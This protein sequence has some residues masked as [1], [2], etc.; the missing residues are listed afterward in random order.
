MIHLILLLC[1]V[2]D[3]HL[4][5]YFKNMDIQLFQQFSE[6][7]ILFPLNLAPLQKLIIHKHKDIFLTL[8]AV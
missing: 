7:T 1:V 2:W 3:K 5:S 6:N 4:S 8:N